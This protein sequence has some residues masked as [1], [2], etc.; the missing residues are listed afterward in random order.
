MDML[1]QR[2]NVGDR[3]VTGSTAPAGLLEIGEGLIV[4]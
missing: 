1:P 2:L 3:I 4:A